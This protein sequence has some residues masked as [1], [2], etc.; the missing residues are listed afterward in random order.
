MNATRAATGSE[1]VLVPSKA[2]DARHVAVHAT[3]TLFLRHVPNLNVARVQ[4][5]GEIMRL[6]VAS[7]SKRRHIRGTFVLLDR[8]ELR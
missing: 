8:Q 2:T 3:K 6:A 1:Y 5:D 4:A 7:P